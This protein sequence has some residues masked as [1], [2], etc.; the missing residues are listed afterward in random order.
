MIQ[1]LT[2]HQIEIEALIEALFGANSDS[3]GQMC[4]YKE[5]KCLKFLQRLK[6]LYLDIRFID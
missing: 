4:V 5:I 1:P 6:K 2:H 3:L